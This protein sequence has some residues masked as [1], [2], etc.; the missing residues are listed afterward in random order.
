MYQF[1]LTRS[2]VPAQSDDLIE[3]TTVGDL[4]RNVAAKHAYAPALVEVDMEG[5]TART[6]TYGELLAEG[7]PC[8]SLN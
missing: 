2:L 4:L 6:W 1:E 7:F 3:E 5:H 8:I